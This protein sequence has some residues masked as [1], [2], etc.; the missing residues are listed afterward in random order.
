MPASNQRKINLMVKAC[1]LVTSFIFVISIVKV[2]EA[3]WQEPDQLP[4]LGQYSYPIT[5]SSNPQAKAGFFQIIGDNSIGSLTVFTGDLE[6]L[7]SDLQVERNL[8]M[9]SGEDGKYLTVGTDALQVRSTPSGMDKV[10]INSNQWDWDSELVV[11]GTGLFVSDLDTA[12][13]VE[14]DESYFSGDWDSAIHVDNNNITPM[15]VGAAIVG[16]S[17]STYGG[18]GILG[19]GGDVLTGSDYSYGIF[20]ES[21]SGRGDDYAAYFDSHVGIDHFDFSYLNQYYDLITPRE[22]HTATLLDDGTVLVAGGI[23]EAGYL[24]SAEIY[25]P[26]TQGFTALVNDMTKRRSSHTATLLDDGRVLLAGG[27]NGGSFLNTAEIYDPL[28]QTFTA[29]GN[30]NESR[31]KHTANLLSNGTVLIIGGSYGAGLYRSTTEIFDPL[32]ETFSPG[33]NLSVG[34]SIHTTTTMPPGASTDVL[35]IV[36]GRDATGT[37]T[38]VEIYRDG[39]ITPLGADLKEDRGYHTA[40]ALD[41]GDLLVVGGY[42]DDGAGGLEARG[43]ELYDSLAGSFEIIGDFLYPRY[44]HSAVKMGNGLVLISGGSESAIKV[45]TEMEVYDPEAGESGEFIDEFN[46]TE[47]DEIVAHTGFPEFHPPSMGTPRYGHT[48]TKLANNQ[49]IIVGG[50]DL[51]GII[52]RDDGSNQ[53]ISEITDPALEMNWSGK[54]N[55]LNAQFLDSHPAEDF[56]DAASCGVKAGALG[57]DTNEEA[58]IHM[59]GLG[60]FDGGLAV[61]LVDSLTESAVSAINQSDFGGTSLYITGPH[62]TLEKPSYGLYSVAQDNNWAGYFEGKIRIETDKSGL[63]SFIYVDSLNNPTKGIESALLSDGRVYLAGGNRGSFGDDDFVSDAYLFDPNTEN[64]Q[65]I[66]PLPS[67]R[68]YHQVTAYGDGVLITGGYNNTSG[69]VLSSAV[70]YQP[71][72]GYQ[73]TDLILPRS[74]HTTTLLE[75]GRVFIAG[76]FD[77]AVYGQA[78]DYTEIYNDGIKSGPKLPDGQAKGN[79]TATLLSDG[80]VLLVGGTDRVNGDY[81]T[82]GLIYD[83]EDDQIDLTA[84]LT[85]SIFHTATLLPNGKVLITGGLYQDK[86]LATA[87]LYDP[88]KDSVIL[89]ANLNLARYGHQA[90]SLSDGRVLLVGGKN[91]N[92]YL[93]SLEIYNPNIGEN[94][95]FQLVQTSLSEPRAFL[96]AVELGSGAV[97]IAGGENQNNKLNSVRLYEPYQPPL[98]VANNSLVPNL[99][100]QYLDGYQ[101]EEIVLASEDINSQYFKINQDFNLPRA[102]DNSLNLLGN[103]W[104]DQE[105]VVENS[106]QSGVTVMAQ[107]NDLYGLYAKNTN[108]S[109]AV[110]SENNDGWA[111]F[112]SNGSKD[113]RTE[114]A[115]KLVMAG[116]GITFTGQSPAGKGAISGGSN[117]VTIASSFMNSASIV[118]LSLTNTGD[119]QQYFTLRVSEKAEGSYTVETYPA[120]AHSGVEFDYMIIN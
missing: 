65:S 81:R 45:A 66:E 54:A 86:A 59:T 77:N 11:E 58:N 20:A 42:T 4:P 52:K 83:S 18:G 17:N 3:A 113:S 5:V 85:Q 68:A 60:I 74:N 69:Q 80:R 43:A 88:A 105:I 89:L 64:L 99:N 57:L 53:S 61:S 100:A 103:I 108:G 38:S 32:T 2:V 93:G 21:G 76:G 6:V 15:S 109:P 34:R 63:G 110:Y 22:M 14:S 56:V 37:L 8:E 30:L 36:G 97:L 104:S 94:G 111:G 75:D 73:K 62:S 117:S 40:T 98:M 27:Y 31:R 118:L 55:N 12:L 102:G 72:I 71:D 28:L 79:H 115:G 116:K 25:D 82:Q 46:Y 1:L 91:E 47:D 106:S 23:G 95:A 70:F 78:V 16:F 7:S 84:S 107:A 120:V 44:N 41:N 39:V 96:T 19:K 48:T 29:V 9:T 49:I 119:S 33:S 50:R 13:V 35:F 114:I 26:L 90:F 112:F 24:Q 101:A 10:R 87:L 92:S 67:A 51:S